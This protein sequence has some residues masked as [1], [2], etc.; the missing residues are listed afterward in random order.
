MVLVVYGVGKD[1][2]GKLDLELRRGGIGGVQIDSLS[3]N[4][5]KFF[6]YQP[7]RG[8]LHRELSF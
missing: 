5:V 4:A 7:N 2:Y 6:D 1:G 8:V 3:L